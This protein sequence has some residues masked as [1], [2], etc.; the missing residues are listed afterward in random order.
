MACPG[1][2][3]C[4]RLGVTTYLLSSPTCH[5]GP[6]PRHPPATHLPRRSHLRSAPFRLSRLLALSVH[7]GVSGAAPESTASADAQEWKR[8]AH[9]G[10]PSSSVPVRLVAEEQGTDQH[11]R[12]H[13][14]HQEGVQVVLSAQSGSGRRSAANLGVWLPGFTTRLC[15]V[16]LR[17]T[18]DPQPARSL[19]GPRARP[20]QA[21]TH[22]TIP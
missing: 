5:R 11:G 15:G 1:R 2:C 8:R 16:Q 17:K 6:A 20:R 19:H 13:E 10:S 22:L 14:E 7:T 21:G 4:H 9:G 3:R 12:R 18:L